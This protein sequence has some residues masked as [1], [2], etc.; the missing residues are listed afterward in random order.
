M[1]QPSSLSASGGCAGSGFAVPVDLVRAADGGKEQRRRHRRQCARNSHVNRPSLM[2][3]ILVRRRRCSWLSARELC[4]S[5]PRRQPCRQHSMAPSWCAR[6][7]RRREFPPECQRRHQLGA[8]GDRAPS[9]KWSRSP[10]HST[11]YAARRAACGPR[12]RGCPRAPGAV[13]DVPEGHVAAARHTAAP[14]DQRV[15]GIRSRHSSPGVSRAPRMGRHARRALRRRT[16]G[17]GIPNGR[18]GFRGE[19]RDRIHGEGGLGLDPY[20]AQ[21]GRPH[22]G[23]VNCRDGKPCCASYPTSVQMGTRCRHRRFRTLRAR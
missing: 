21:P 12:S 10:C 4:V 19:L 16:D 17:G 6:C 14:N 20:G 13:A 2:R 3:R 22:P 15:K 11:R 8:S 23:S 18:G 7:D 1:P 5:Y 9:P